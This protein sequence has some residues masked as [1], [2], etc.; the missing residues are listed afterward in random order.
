MRSSAS[1]AFGDILVRGYPPATEQRPVYDLYRTPVSGID[2]VASDFPQRH[3]AQDGGAK[4]VNV[5]LKGTGFF[6]ICYQIAKAEARLH[7]IRR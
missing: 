2:D 6:S 5:A 3:V 4:L 1:F 7:H